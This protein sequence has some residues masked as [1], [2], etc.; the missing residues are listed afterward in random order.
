MLSI[1]RDLLENYPKGV[2]QKR[3]RL[4]CMDGQMKAKKVEGFLRQEDK[5]MTRFECEIKRA[6]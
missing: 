1:I 5:V 4:A 3:T 2:A 6:F